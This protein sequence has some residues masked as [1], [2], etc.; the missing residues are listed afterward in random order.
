M[1]FWLLKLLSEKHEKKQNKTKIN[2]ET[3]KK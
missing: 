2:Q 3:I 1:D